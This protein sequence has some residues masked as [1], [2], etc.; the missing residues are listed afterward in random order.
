MVSLKIIPLHL[1]QANNYVALHHRH[2]KP[3]VGCK[4]S[5]G[6]WDIETSSIVGV[7]IC[8][9]PVSRKL[10]NGFT[11]EVYRVCTNGV[12]NVCSMLYSACFRVA[13]EMGYCRIITYTLKS[14][15]GT[16]LK[17]S[18]FKLCNES[19]G[20]LS[21]NV[22]SR[23]RLDYSVDLFGYERKLPNELKKLWE[24]N[25]KSFFTI[26]VEKCSET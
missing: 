6:V 20:G 15:L 22:P 2:N 17:A 19:C 23:N 21:W 16:S 4:F 9:R 25:L 3:V 8:G 12:K 26:G 24:R 7:A 11:L 18:H 13:K 10:D 14:E 5:L 1:K